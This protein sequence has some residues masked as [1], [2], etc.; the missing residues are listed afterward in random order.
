MLR[1]ATTFLATQEHFHLLPKTR[2][3]ANTQYLANRKTTNWTFFTVKYCAVK[4]HVLA[5]VWWRPLSPLES[6]LFCNA[7]LHFYQ[8]P[9]LPPVCSAECADN[10]PRRPDAKPTETERGLQKW[11][12]VS[13]GWWEGTLHKKAQREGDSICSWWHGTS[14]FQVK[15]LWAWILILPLNTRR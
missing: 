6:K 7:L 2:N 14:R 1:H 13:G 11:R 4:L 12:D 10:L 9:P 3:T 15:H 5:W 8:Q